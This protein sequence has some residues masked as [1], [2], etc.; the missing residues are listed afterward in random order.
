MAFP[1][2]RPTLIQRIV[3]TGDNADWRQ[4]LDDY[5]GPVCRFAA[6]RSSLGVADVEDIASQTF[7]ALIS[8]KLL[9][10]WIVNR[11][12]KLRTLICTVTR[13][14][15]S[16]RA[17]VDQGRARLMREH[18]DQGGELVGLDAP[19]EQVDRFYAAW[20]E[21]LIEQAVESLLSEYH[22]AGKGDYFRVLHGRLCEQM[23]MGEV[24]ELLDL[25]ITS[26]ENYF[27]AARKR[28]TTILQ[29]LVRQHVERYA[30]NADQDEFAAEWHALGEYL[31]EHGGLEDAVRRTY[32]GAN[33]TSLRQRKTAQI[34]LTLSRISSFE[35]E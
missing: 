30:A 33:V 20:V 16:N 8:N 27:K 12:A 3:S 32:E 26:A 24:A 29:D 21:D 4:F 19:V 11:S 1:E 2:T 31:T 34:N 13:N 17:R 6:Y 5:W 14:V 10:R 35:A 28:L 7:E 18:L 23:A 9:A 22:Q 15:M 25:K